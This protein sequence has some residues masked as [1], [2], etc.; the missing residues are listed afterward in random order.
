[1]NFFANL[2]FN[3]KSEHTPYKGFKIKLETQ[4]MEKIK[5][6]NSNN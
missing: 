5:K 3:Q 6:L 4:F 2:I 1:M